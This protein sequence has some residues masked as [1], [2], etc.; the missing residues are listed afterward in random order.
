MGLSAENYLRQMQALL[1]LGPAWPRSDDAELTRLLAG[2]SSEFALI[3]GRATQLAEE[4]DPRT[5]AELFG[6]WERVAGFP[7][8]CVEAYA[9]SNE[10]SARRAAL[11]GRLATLGGQSRAY[12]VAVAAALGYDISISEFVP[13]SVL[14]DVEASV[15]GQRWAFAWQVN[16]GEY[17]V[18]EISTESLVTEP[19]AAWGNDLLECVIKRLKPAHTN[20]L[21]AY[22]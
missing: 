20:V 19:L 6:D 5:T 7:Y 18:N 2:L 16:A 17:S 13:H 14:D 1:P 8:S 12:F 10:Q 4:S 9:T 11:L 15:V 22:S 21:F 3:D